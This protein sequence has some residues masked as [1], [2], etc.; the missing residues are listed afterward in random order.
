[1]LAPGLPPIANIPN[2]LAAGFQ[3]NSEHVIRPIFGKVR[4]PLMAPENLFLTFRP[5]K[6]LHHG[7]VA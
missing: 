6:M 1:L 2:T 4:V 7:R 5:T 3:D